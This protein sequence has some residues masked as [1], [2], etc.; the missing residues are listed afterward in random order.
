MNIARKISEVSKLTGEFVLRS[1]QV[2]D[3]YFD[4]YLFESDPVLLKAI[5]E[6]MAELVPSDTEVLAG[7]DLGGIP[8]VTA[9]SQVT[10]IPAAFIRKKP[11][12]YGTRK[13]AEGA[14]LTSKNVVLVED[15]VSTGGAILNILAMLNADGIAPT[16]ALCVI[17]RETGGVEALRGQSVELR[18]LLTMS[19]IENA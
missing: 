1:G 5:A 18:A 7:L 2:T 12:E 4:K 10:G 15:V 6:E 8:L 3:T 11:K 17:D 13:Y 16:L 9:L 14:D 19:E